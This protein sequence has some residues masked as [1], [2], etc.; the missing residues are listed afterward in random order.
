MAKS[1]DELCL[2]QAIDE[3]N[4]QQDGCGKR[5]QRRGLLE[6]SL[7]YFRRF[8]MPEARD[9]RSPESAEEAR[10]LLASDEPIHLPVFVRDS[11]NWSMIDREHFRGPIEQLFNFLH[12]PDEEVEYSDH[13]KPNIHKTM[14]IG[15]LR[16]R[17]AKHNGQTPRYPRNFR[18][19][20]NPMPDCGIPHFMQNNTCTLLHDIMRRQL[21]CDPSCD[22]DV[23]DRLGDRC[24]HRMKHEDYMIVQT[25]WRYWKGTVMLAEPGAITLPH[26]DKYSTSTWISC[27]E[28]E[29]GFGWLAEPHEDE[30]TA[31]LKD[32]SEPQGRYLFKMLRPGDA[33][34]MPPGTIHF[35][36]RRPGGGQTMGFA[37]QMIR[38]ADAMSWLEYLKIE[39]GFAVEDETEDAP[40]ERVVP[41]MMQ[42]LIHLINGA[43]RQ[44]DFDKYGGKQKLEELI[45]VAISVDDLIEELQ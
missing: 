40:Y 3:F 12:D 34:Y 17:F 45:D 35:V 9:A 29:M 33:V 15:E 38:R 6:N 8:E 26:W 14:P 11:A 5:S 13:S 23:D 21:D 37:G 1:A 41:Q 22:C 44:K 4:K 24:E 36:F 10:R 31:W 19:L 2:Q 25:M 42:G 20:V 43:L 32:V 16:K 27:L 30:K 28:G 39:L 18:D 7:K